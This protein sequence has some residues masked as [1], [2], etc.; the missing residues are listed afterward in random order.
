[1]SY[2]ILIYI[3]WTHHLP[4]LNIKGGPVIG[5]ILTSPS[6]CTF[7]GLAISYRYCKG[8]IIHDNP[9]EIGTTYTFTKAGLWT[10]TKTLAMALA[11]HIRVNAIGP[12]PTLP[13]KRQTKKQFE[14]QFKTMPLKK[15]VDSKEIADA[16]L[17]I[18]RSNSRLYP[19][20]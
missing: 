10:L 15:A 12:G 19:Q 9:R 16:I 18:L 4:L 14:N 2:P 3:H 17:F 7:S 13:S 11:P 8:K 20:T 5:L 6:L 1:M